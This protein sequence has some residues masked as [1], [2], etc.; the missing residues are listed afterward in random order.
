MYRPEG[1]RQI[2]DMLKDVMRRN[3]IE[4]FIG[5]D[6]G[7]QLPFAHI[8]GEIWVEVASI[9]IQARYYVA[10][11]LRG[12]Q[13]APTAEADVEQRCRSPG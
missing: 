4:R 7:E 8:A 12:T 2:F 10:A 5:K 3:D 13:K 9:K 6:A 11:S 1:L